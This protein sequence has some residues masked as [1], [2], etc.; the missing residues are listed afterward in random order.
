MATSTEVQVTVA[1][2][3]IT[4]ME[5]R[6]LTPFFERML[7]YIKQNVIGLHA[8]EVTLHQD[9]VEADVQR[10]IITVRKTG[11]RD[12]KDWDN[13]VDWLV[14]NIPPDIFLY[15]LYKTKYEAENGR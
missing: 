12:L 5:G 10:I 9:P 1:P 15:F 8:I 13:W 11:T 4:F 14:T 7:D 3:V 2:E 6:M